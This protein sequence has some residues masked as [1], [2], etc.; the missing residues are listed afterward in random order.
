M[1]RSPAGN[2]LLRLFPE[3]RREATCGTRR[4]GLDAEAVQE[5]LSLSTITKW[6]HVFL[7]TYILIPRNWVNLIIWWAKG[8][9]I[10]TADC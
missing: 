7:S 4:D 3:L 5:F 1:R 10:R 2:D 6:L 8:Y 9:M